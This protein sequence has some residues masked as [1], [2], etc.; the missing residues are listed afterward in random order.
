M[1]SHD[2]DAYIDFDYE[3]VTSPM[4]AFD[5]SE[6]AVGALVAA[7]GLLVVFGLPLLLV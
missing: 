4:Q 1:T 5:T 7:V 2:T 6:V 3:R